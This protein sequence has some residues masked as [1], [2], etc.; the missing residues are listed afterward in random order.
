MLVCWSMKESYVMRCGLWAGVMLLA[1]VVGTV[2]AAPGDD[3]I[4]LARD[5]AGRG[6][7]ATLASLAATPSN[8]PLEPYVQYWLLSARIA[9]LAEP[10]DGQLVGSFLSANTGS[11]LAD[12]LRG[13][14]ARRL[15]FEKRWPEFDA[16]YG[17]LQQPD[18]AT[19]CYAIQG[20][21]QYAS[22]ANRA[23]AAQWLTLNDVPASC[24][25]P[26][27]NLALSG[28]I[29]SENMWQRF[30]RLVENKRFPAARN[31]LGWIG[32]GQIPTALNTA[33]NSP[34]R[35]LA[36]ARSSSNRMD[37]ELILAA[38]ARAARND[39]RIAASRW[40]GIEGNSFSS[41]ERAYAWGQLGWLGGLSRVP[42]AAAWYKLAKGT[43]MS[44]EQRAWNIRAHLRI[45]DWA[46]VRQAI[47]ELPADQRD[48]PDWTYWLGRA[49]QAQGQT[50]A[51][52]LQFQ[53]YADTPSF[54]GILSTEALGRAYAWP[55]AAAPATADELAQV[56][57]LPDFRRAAALYQLD[58]R[59]EGLREWN[60]GLR[61][62]NDRYLL[63]AA[64][65][66]RQLGLYDRAIS[67]AERTRT[68]HDFSLRYLAPYYDVFARNADT[69]QLDLA[70]VYG[71]VRQESR[72]QSVARSGAGAQ[73]LMQVMPAT[74]KWIAGKQGWSDYHSGWLTGIDTNVRLGSAYL[75][76]VLDTLSNHR[77][78]ATAA[79]NAGPSRARRWRDAKPIEGAIYTETIPF[80][81]TRDYVK[82]VMANAELYAT[83]FDK[84]PISLGSRLGTVPAA[85]QD[86]ALAPD[87]P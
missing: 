65:H 28:Q 87:E 72:F 86:V 82:K 67:S 45:S 36:S 3:R 20:G 51:A 74:G 7:V 61:G 46:G 25:Q 49:L 23:L 4:L 34:E 26:L 47:E 55:A 1:G 14:W 17:L 54:Y 81:E 50:D 62:A 11:M 38:V 60:W 43:D 56:R 42:E 21:G 52:R 73:G 27:Q 5:A 63:A 53:R 22:E 33:L 2:A 70:W 37:R 29:S 58:L 15:G 64:E 57:A 76:H 16:Q 12:R 77:V 30:R 59:T 9:R 39:V 41:E 35:Y 18:L 31:V 19:Q 68:E 24:E 40:R 48:T 71:L 10:V 75:R 6:D 69:Q 83:L 32:N 85:A 8:H 13:E 84:R 80:T 66:A 79:Y 78:L 44:A